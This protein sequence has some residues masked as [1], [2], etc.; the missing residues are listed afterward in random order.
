MAT[1]HIVLSALKV[2]EVMLESHHMI[3]FSLRDHSMGKRVSTNDSDVL[4]LV[5]S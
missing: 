5:L 3:N 1:A 2:R 4:F